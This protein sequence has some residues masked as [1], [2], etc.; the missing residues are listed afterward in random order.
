MRLCFVVAVAENG[1]IGAQGAMPWR[2]PSDL[3]RFKRMT[4]GKPVI[5]GRK[6]YE[7]IGRPLPG[8]DNIVITRSEAFAPEGVFIV[9]SVD[10]ALRL[11][12]ARATERGVDEIAVIGGGGVFREMLPLAERIY[13]TRVH[14]AP[15]GDVLFPELVRDE[16]E[17]IERQAFEAQEGDTADTTL[18]VLQRKRALR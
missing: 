7:S 2:L 10:A 17:E 12:V 15:A 16:W 8:R 11:A 5:M 1:V 4:M 18:I 3:A 9:R 14:A 6:T 13:L